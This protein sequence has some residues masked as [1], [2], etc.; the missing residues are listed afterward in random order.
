MKT[1]N[2]LFA[3]HNHQPVGN[4]EHVFQEAWEK[5]YNP[6]LNVLEKHPEFRLSMHY[7]GSLLEWFEENQPGFLPRLRA[8]VARG[9]VELLSG[10]FYEPLLPF[11]P[12]RDAV[13]QIDF[14]NQYLMEKLNA[15]PQGLW[16]AERVW[17]STLP[18]TIAPTGLKYTLV[19]DSHFHYA[20][21]SDEDMFG[22]YVTEQDGFTLCIFPINKRLRY[23]I[24]FRPPEETIE[25]LRFWA[26]DSGSLAVTYADDGEKFGLWPGTSRWV[27]EEGWLEKFVASL[28]ENRDWVHMLTF[29]EYMGKYP[30]QGRTYLPPAS[31]DEMME[32]ALPALSAIGF[33]DM[34][35]ELK[36]DGRYEKYRAF[37]RGGS[38]ENFLVKYTESNHMHK[39]MLQ[40]SEKVHRILEKRPSPAKETEQPPLPALRA[41]WKGQVN[42]AYWHGLFGGLYLNYLRH[43]VYQNLIAAE[44]LAEIIE[45]GGEKYLT[46][47]VTDFDKDL[48][49]KYW[50]PARTWRPSSSQTT[51]VR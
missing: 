43:S 17:N 9:Q 25:A 44:R 15:S 3:V 6:F 5:C 2:L 28:E 21:L 10:G 22:H 38:W 23:A 39:K 32:W 49:L 40:V 7:S 14:F 13:G 48:S 8:L 26:T 51:G 1:I 29:S 45:K 46:F 11:I 33:E 41:L 18:K 36:K 24:P 50:S 16:L 35:E 47:E 34:V 19:D 20:G 27:F 12:E 42:C 4:F 30:P 31:Y 37:L